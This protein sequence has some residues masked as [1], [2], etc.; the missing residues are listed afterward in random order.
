MRLEIGENKEYRAALRPLFFVL[1]M[2]DYGGWNVPNDYY[3]VYL[4]RLKIKSNGKG[5]T[6]AL[7]CADRGR[8]TEGLVLQQ[9]FG[10]LHGVDGGASRGD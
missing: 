2:E 5:Y 6:C 10:S 3:L 9:H 8:E 7:D 4:R 1:C